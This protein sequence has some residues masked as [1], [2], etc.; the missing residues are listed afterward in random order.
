[1]SRLLLVAA[2]GLFAARPAAAADWVQLFNGKDLT[3][4]KLPEPPAGHFENAV[5]VKN[6]EGKVEAYTAKEKKGGKEWTIWQVKD[7]LLVGG[8][9]MSHL[10]TDKEYEDFHFKLECKLTDGSNSGQFFRSGFRPGVPKGYE[11]Q[12]NATHGDRIKTG[13]LYPN[14]EFGLDKHRKEIV[15][16]LDKAAH[17]PDEFFTQEVIC[18]GPKITIKVNGKTTL[19]W[20]DPE[21]RFKKGHLAVQG[22]DPKSVMIFRKIE[23][24]EIK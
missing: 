17:G 9:P 3:G 12:L 11:A 20:T 19:D 21:H 18:Q 15:T 22:H 2:L 5:P 1:M 13:S 16:V 14:G 8:G 10:F 23:V 6:V 24:M 7:G 4:W